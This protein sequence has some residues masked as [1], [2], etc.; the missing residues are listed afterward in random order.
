MTTM[1]VNPDSQT[2]RAWVRFRGKKNRQFHF[3]L[4]GTHLNKEASLTKGAIKSPWVFENAQVCVLI[5]VSQGASAV[6]DDIQ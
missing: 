5:T 4:L 6:L 3:A 2:T 1:P